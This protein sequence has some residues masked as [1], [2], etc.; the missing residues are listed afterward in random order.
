MIG[1]DFNIN[2]IADNNLSFNFKNEVKSC[3]LNFVNEE[4]PTHFQGNASLIDH[5]LVSNLKSIIKYQ[6]FTS[7]GHSN[8]DLLFVIY[9]FS[10]N[11]CKE[12]Q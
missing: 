10:L 12:E 3:G 6:Q 8:H 2:I 1:G 9:D 7:P 11:E 4:I 5:F